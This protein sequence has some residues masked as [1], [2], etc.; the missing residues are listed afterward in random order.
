[1]NNCE[2]I[3]N[4]TK[5]PVLR[6]TQTGKAVA[7]F[8]IATNEP[9]TTPGGEQKQLT[10]YINVVVWG[11]LAQAAAHVL[12]K[13]TR[14]L[15]QGRQSTRS[16]TGQDGQKRWVTEVVARVIA[17]P[18]VPQQPQ[19]QAPQQPQQNWAQGQPAQQQGAQMPGN[20]PGW[21]QFG[22][23]VPQPVDMFGNDNGMPF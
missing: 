23:V 14:V 4:L 17:M 10:D 2:F 9:Y 8:S 11:N 3:G 6:S 1:M 7:S 15:V 21:G 20:S 12:R 16:Y 18:L 22:Q 5:D 13:G 19:Q